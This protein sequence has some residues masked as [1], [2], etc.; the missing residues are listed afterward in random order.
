MS[1]I[2]YPKKQIGI[3]PIC[4]ILKLTVA[5]NDGKLV[6]AAIVARTKPACITCKHARQGSKLI[7]TA[8][9]INSVVGT[10]FT[11]PYACAGSMIL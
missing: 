9:G 2:P 10:I 7:N 3:V 5:E 4:S 6:V 8:R 11:W 1:D